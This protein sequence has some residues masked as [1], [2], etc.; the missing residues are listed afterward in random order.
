MAR[1]N[2][3]KF[4][5]ISKTDAVQSNLRV[6]LAADKV[7]LEPAVKAQAFNE[8]EATKTVLKAFSLQRQ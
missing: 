7:H 3:L 8:K 6:P 4:K 1:H 2:R 5:R